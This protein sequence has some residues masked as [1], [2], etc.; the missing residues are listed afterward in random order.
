MI[1]SV[2]LVPKDGLQIRSN[3]NAAI[4]RLLYQPHQRDARQRLAA[5]VPA[6]QVTMHIHEPDLLQESWL[7][8]MADSIQNAFDPGRNESEPGY[9]E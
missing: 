1:S 5:S 6:S 7:W 3:V 4:R 8:A 2:V 9:A